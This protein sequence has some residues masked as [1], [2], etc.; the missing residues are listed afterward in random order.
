MEFLTKNKKKNNL[1]I[2]F[3][4][5]LSLSRNRG[6][7][8]VPVFKH[9]DNVHTPQ[10]HILCYN[11]HT[12]HFPLIRIYYTCWVRFIALEKEIDYKFMYIIYTYSYDYRHKYVLIKTCNDFNVYEV[13]SSFRFKCCEEY[14]N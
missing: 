4:R 12:Q 7:N 14:L 13:I 8:T 11:L 6:R 9:L 10:N 5:W 1:E 3:L 2:C